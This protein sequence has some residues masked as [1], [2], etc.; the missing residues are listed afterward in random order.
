MGIVGRQWAPWTSSGNKKLTL[1]LRANE[2]KSMWRCGHTWPINVTIV[3]FIIFIQM[4][5][6]LKVFW[7]HKYNLSNIMCYD[8]SQVNIINSEMNQL[9][10]Q[11][12][13]PQKKNK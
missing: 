1:P 10:Q 3:F 8:F 2:F 7:N 6:L 4:Q 12:P 11:Q 5:Y 13:P 9:L